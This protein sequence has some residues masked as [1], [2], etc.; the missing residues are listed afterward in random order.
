MSSTFD[1]RSADGT[2]VR[3][4]SNDGPGPPVVLSNG[5]GAIPQSWPALAA[6]DSGYAVLSWYH[7]GTFDT[8]RPA[9]PSHVRVEDHVEDM[10]ALMDDRGIDRAL[11][12]C[13]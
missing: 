10:V 5:L 4:W 9:D 2:V 7:R 11:V 6:A 3:G 12:A 1:V 8:P 13:W